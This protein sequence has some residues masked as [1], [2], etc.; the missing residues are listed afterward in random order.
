MAPHPQT[1][2]SISELATIGALHA[3]KNVKQRPFYHWLK[4]NYGHLFPK[5]PERTRLF[6]R[7]E[8][9]SSWTGTSWPRPLSWASPTATALNCAIR[10]APSVI[11]TRQARRVSP[12]TPGSFHRWIVGGKLCIVINQ[13]GLITDWDCRTASV[14]DQTLMTKLSD[15]CW[16]TTTDG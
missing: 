6:R 5:L 9:Q 14:H 4:N 16:N 10:C 8:T 3:I 7:L 12:I 1:R 11:S 2:L 15:T 13:L